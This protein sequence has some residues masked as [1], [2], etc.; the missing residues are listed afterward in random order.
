MGEVPH[1]WDCR[2]DCA[3]WVSDMDYSKDPPEEGH[4]AIL[5]IATRLRG[6]DVTTHKPEY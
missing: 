6:L 1:T 3:W 5:E 2:K 4:C